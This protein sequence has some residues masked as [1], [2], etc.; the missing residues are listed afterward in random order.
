MYLHQRTSQRTHSLNVSSYMNVAE[1]ERA[2]SSAAFVNVMPVSCPELTDS[3]NKIVFQVVDASATH[4]L[5]L[6]SRGA[7]F[8]WGENSR[9]LGLVYHSISIVTARI[10]CIS[11]ANKKLESFAL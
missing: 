6:T 1:D 9:G 2:H 3:E 7:A 5:V 10:L 8:A 4:S 11:W